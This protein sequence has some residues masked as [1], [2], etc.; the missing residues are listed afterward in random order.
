MENEGLTALVDAAVAFRTAERT[1]HLK[2]EDAAAQLVQW[3]HG[4]SIPGIRRKHGDAAASMTKETVLFVLDM[5]R[6]ELI[7]LAT[8]RGNQPD[9]VVSPS[10]EREEEAPLFIGGTATP[11]RDEGPP[12]GPIDA[13]RDHLFRMHFDGPGDGDELREDVVG[14]IQAYHRELWAELARKGMI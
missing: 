10:P 3:A 2:I 5:M 12:E 8:L 4:I 1:L 14:A 9:G 7:A 13:A 6:P 11:I